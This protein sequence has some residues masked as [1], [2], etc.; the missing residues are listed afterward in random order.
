MAKG[1]MIGIRIKED[2]MYDLE[3]YAEKEG[4]FLTEL[5]RKILREEVKRR[6]EEARKKEEE[7]K[8][9]EIA[10]EVGEAPKEKTSGKKE[11]KKE[12]DKNWP[13]IKP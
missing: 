7:R 8:K 10:I 5:I 13:F 2:L 6:R 11:E 12:L 3:N 9:D 4:M 1:K